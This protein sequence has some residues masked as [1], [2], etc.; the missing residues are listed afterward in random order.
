[1]AAEVA[2]LARLFSTSAERPADEAFVASVRQRMVRETWA[3]RAV[4]VS[5]ALMLAATAAILL[6]PIAQALALIGQ[7]AGLIAALSASL[8]ALPSGW[9]ALAAVALVLWAA[10][11]ASSRAA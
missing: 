3:S 8:L 6:G 1:M 2:D 5:L 10:S 7:A 9:I 11:A 4:W